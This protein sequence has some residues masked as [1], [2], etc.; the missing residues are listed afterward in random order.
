MPRRGAAS[1]SSAGK[2]QTEPDP[3]DEKAARARARSRAVQRRLRWMFCAGV[4]FAFSVGIALQ[5]RSDGS[6]KGSVTDREPTAAAD[7]HLRSSRRS[8]PS[9][10]AAKPV[11]LTVQRDLRILHRVINDYKG[12]LNLRLANDSA[13]YKR[14]INEFDE[15]LAN[16]PVSAVPVCAHVVALVVTPT[17]GC[18]RL[19]R[20]ALFTQRCAVLI[21]CRPTLRRR[22][23]VESHTYGSR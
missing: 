10:N 3:S 21:H 16:I 9:S 22:L 11:Q 6:G 8:K 4:L 5:S 14:L 15:A 2:A 23:A 17:H 7:V 1:R 18:R 19:T 12:V 20:T 13:L